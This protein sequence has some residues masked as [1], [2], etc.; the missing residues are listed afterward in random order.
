MWKIFRRKTQEEKE[1]EELS[2][3][4]K[5]E[6]LNMSTLFSNLNMR[7][8]IDAFPTY[9]I[10]HIRTDLSVTMRRWCLPTNSSNK[11]K[12]ARLTTRNYLP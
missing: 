6:P 1:L 12:R 5:S 2:Q 8:E 4:I 7:G 3:K 9:V 11:F 10:V